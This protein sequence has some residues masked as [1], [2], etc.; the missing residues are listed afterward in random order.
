[1]EAIEDRAYGA[2]LGVFVADAFLHRL[3]LKGEDDRPPAPSRPSEY[4]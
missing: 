4:G 3:S 2:L 1:M